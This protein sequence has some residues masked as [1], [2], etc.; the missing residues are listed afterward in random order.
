[1]GAATAA[2]GA[3]VSRTQLATYLPA[4]LASGLLCIVAAGLT[5]RLNAGAGTPAP[6]RAGA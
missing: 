6:L 3:G 4:F 5:L 2:I 1:L